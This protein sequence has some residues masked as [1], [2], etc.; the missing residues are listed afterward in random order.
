MALFDTAK[1]ALLMASNTTGHQQELCT[2]TKPHASHACV[3]ALGGV[4]GVNGSLSAYATS[5]VN[6]RASAEMNDFHSFALT[7]SAEA[8]FGGHAC[9]AR[10]VRVAPQ[11]IVLLLPVEGTE[12]C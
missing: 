11:C 3:Q 12:G 6:C 10:Q 9:G 5:C 8:S 4:E 2:L 7:A 1:V